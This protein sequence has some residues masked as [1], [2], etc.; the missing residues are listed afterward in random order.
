MQVHT[1]A[2]EL[3]AVRSEQRQNK[4]RVQQLVGDI[5]ATGW[6]RSAMHAGVGGWLGRADG[7]RFEGATNCWLTN[8]NAGES[9]ALGMLGVPE[10]LS[11]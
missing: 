9:E 11:A 5:C 2:A 3:D 1:L 10:C 8:P 4:E 7:A 6:N